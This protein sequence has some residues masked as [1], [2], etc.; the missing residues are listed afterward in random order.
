MVIHDGI[1]WLGDK[2]KHYA[3]VEDAR[4]SLSLSFHW[5]PPSAEKLA[6][7]RALQDKRKLRVFLCHAHE[8]KDHVRSLHTWLTSIGYEPWLDEVN[9]VPGQRWRDVIPERI[10]ESDAFLACLSTK[11]ITKTGYIQKEIRLALEFLEEMPAGHIFFIPACLEPCDLPRRISDYQVCK[12]YE[13]KGRDLLN[14]ALDTVAVQ[15]DPDGQNIFRTR[16]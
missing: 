12:L 5:E 7:V 10:R 16:A 14:Q 2:G 4:R 6:E 15:I 3:T 1:G 13:P 11:A 8:D 9:L